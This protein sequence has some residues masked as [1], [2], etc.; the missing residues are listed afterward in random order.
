MSEI[1]ILVFVV[2]MLTLAMIAL[3]VVLRWAITRLRAANA[4]LRTQHE[5]AIE[6]DKESEAA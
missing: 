5:P 4:R 6:G 1:T 2:G 3:N